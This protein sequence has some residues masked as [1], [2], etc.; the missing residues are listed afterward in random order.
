MAREFQAVENLLENIDPEFAQVE[1]AK[2]VVAEYEKQKKKLVWPEKQRLLTSAT[3]GPQM[4]SEFPVDVWKE[5]IRRWNK[6]TPDE[7]GQWTSTA[8]KNLEKEIEMDGSYTSAPARIRGEFQPVRH[9]VVL[10]CHS[11]GVPCWLAR[12]FRRRLIG[13]VALIVEQIFGETPHPARPAGA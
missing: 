4:G 1:L 8:K 10:A 5:T 2:K 6:L 12:C 11:D 7:K 3:K 9:I 13:Y